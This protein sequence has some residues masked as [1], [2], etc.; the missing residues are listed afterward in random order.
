MPS[1][2]KVDTK[3]FSQSCTTPLVSWSL[4]R[5]GGQNLSEVEKQVTVT[6]CKV[7]PDLCIHFF[8]QI[9]HDQRQAPTL[10]LVPLALSSLNNQRHFLTFQSFIAP[11]PYA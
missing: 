11:S 6:W 4:I 9:I 1:S 5:L 10:F 7:F 8:F 3:S 2:K